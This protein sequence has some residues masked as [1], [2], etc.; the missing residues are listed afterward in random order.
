M[1]REDGDSRFANLHRSRSIPTFFSEVERARSTAILAGRTSHVRATDG[2]G[3]LRLRD[4]TRFRAQRHYA[5]DDNSEVRFIEENY[6][7]AIRNTGFC[8][9]F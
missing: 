5:Q 9:G 2:V 3:V 4:A 1:L 6:G 7:P 8:G